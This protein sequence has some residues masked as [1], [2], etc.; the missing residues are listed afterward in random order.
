MCGDGDLV[1]VGGRDADV[2]VGILDFDLRIGRD[3]GVEYGL[4]LI[5]LRLAEGAEEVVSIVAHVVADG[6]PEVVK[7]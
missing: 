1:A 7:P 5:M 4:V 2:A 6:A 3:G